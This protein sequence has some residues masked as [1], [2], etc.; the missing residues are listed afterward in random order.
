M[1][2]LDLKILQ[3]A[4]ASEREVLFAYLF[5]SYASGEQTPLSDIDVAVYPTRKLSLDERLG[6]IQRLGKKTSHE[7]LDITFLD[8]LDNLDLLR[9]ITTRGLVLLDKD[10]D[11]REL[12]EVRVQHDYFD[13]NDQRKRI[14][15]EA[16]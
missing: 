6:V 3:D 5:G 7:N 16:A 11:A 15:G 13:F 14:F 2:E 4:L 10:L 1:P 12:F 8:R 9:A